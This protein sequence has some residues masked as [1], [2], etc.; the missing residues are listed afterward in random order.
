MARVKHTAVRNS[1]LPA[2]QP[3]NSS[4]HKV[5]LPKPRKHRYKVGISALREIRHWQ[6]QVCQL[7][8]TR[9]FQRLVRSVT[10]EISDKLQSRPEQEGDYRWGAEALDAIQEAAEAYMVQIFEDANL[11]CIH[12]GRVTVMPKDIQ[13]ARRLR[14]ER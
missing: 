14:G 12:A 13:L 5:S 10:R 9:P 3:L 4:Y 1:Q 6:K 7:I 8:R 2:T 11:C